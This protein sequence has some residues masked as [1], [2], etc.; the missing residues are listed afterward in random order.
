MSDE[1]QAL[2]FQFC[3]TNG[4]SQV[5]LMKSSQTHVL[6]TRSEDFIVN[7]VVIT[8]PETSPNTDG[9]HISSAT[10]IVIANSIIGTGMYNFFMPFFFL[11]DSQFFHEV[12]VL[13]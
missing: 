6:I 1:L 9:I 7:D 12:F 11:F 5:R 8:A 10:N 3:K 13:R 2:T 4:L